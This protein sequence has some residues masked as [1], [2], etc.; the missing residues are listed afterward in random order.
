[1]RGIYLL[2]LS[3]DH[4]V[5]NST[6]DSGGAV[7]NPSFYSVVANTS[8]TASLVVRVGYFGVCMAGGSEGDPS[9]WTCRPKAKDIAEQVLESQ[10]PL[11]VL[12]VGD[13]FRDQVI[14]SVIM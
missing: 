6:L 10:D 5:S 1:M 8:S 11:N 3:Y 4:Q 14:V 7:T 12:A 9:S 2:Q 13:N